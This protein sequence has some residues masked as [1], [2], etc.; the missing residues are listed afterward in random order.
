M[1][2][3]I[4]ATIVLVVG[5]VVYLFAGPTSGQA[6]LPEA[7][8]PVHE[9]G[10]ANVFVTNE[11]QPVEVSHEPARGR[12]IEFVSEPLTMLPGD[13]IFTDA[14][15][16]SDCSALWMAVSANP[17]SLVNASVWTEFDGKRTTISG[18]EASLGNDPAFV[19]LMRTLGT[20]RIYARAPSL[21][22]RLLT[23]G[24]SPTR[25]EKVSLYCE[26]Y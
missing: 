8:I 17:I 2:Q 6:T 26:P 11:P 24:S 9:Q 22:V 15:D 19:P 14:K 23:S 10:I 13:V 16:T 25:V 3:A 7:T 5:G 21:M 4:V 18:P 20:Q 1:K 12:Y